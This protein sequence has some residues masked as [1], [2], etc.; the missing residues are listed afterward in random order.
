MRY[1]AGIFALLTAAAGWYYLFYSRAAHR[2]SGVEEP[3]VNERRIRLRRV[4]GLAM[5]LLGAFLFAGTYAF[6][7]PRQ[8]PGAFLGV[9]LTV[10][11]LLVVIV[12][13]AMV[14]V[15]LTRRMRA[16]QRGSRS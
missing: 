6:E 8:T 1:L 14:D 2:L 16:R 9:W 12:V 4:S 13:L 5:V 10:F 15:R 11:V 3:A 7:N